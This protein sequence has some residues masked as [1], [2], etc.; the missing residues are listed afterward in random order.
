MRKSGY[1]GRI[2]VVS[3]EE[4][5]PYDRPPLSKT[6]LTEEQE[7][8]P[9]YFLDESMIASLKA[10]FMRGGQQVTRAMVA[11]DD[12]V[13]DGSVAALAS[14][15]GRVSDGLRG[16]QNG[17]ARTYALAMLGGAAL[18]AGAVLILAVWR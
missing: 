6:M 18:I 12:R 13:I 10:V 4:H 9:V 15:V 5:L 11:V 3:D 17:F 1:S 14:G 16:L 2:T 8:T 7:P